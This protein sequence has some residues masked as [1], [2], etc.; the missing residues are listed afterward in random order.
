MR[1]TAG[2][3]L[4]ESQVERDLPRSHNYLLFYTELPTWFLTLRVE[5]C[6]TKW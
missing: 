3:Y 6:A 2:Y 1:N 4:T 5:A